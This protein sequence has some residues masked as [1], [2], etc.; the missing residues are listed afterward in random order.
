MLIEGDAAVVW[1]RHGFEVD[2]ELSHVGVD[3]FHLLRTEEG[4]K[5]AGGAYSVVR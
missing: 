4:W 5:V 2:G 3:A 1:G